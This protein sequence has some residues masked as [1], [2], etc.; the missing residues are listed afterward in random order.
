MFLQMGGFYYFWNTAPSP[1][2]SYADKAK[3]KET[4]GAPPS[5]NLVALHIWAW[6]PPCDPQ[7]SYFLQGGWE[8]KANWS[9]FKAR[10]EGSD[11][12]S[13]CEME[14]WAVAYCADWNVLWDLLCLWRGTVFLHPPHFIR[15]GG[16]AGS[17][18]N[19]TMWFNT[20]KT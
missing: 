13:S 19:S 16:G 2:S 6:C 11:L 12:R 5:D 18:Q 9:S 3:A 7:S 14:S 10:V 1:K 20:V 8:W 4:C 17:L 15:Q